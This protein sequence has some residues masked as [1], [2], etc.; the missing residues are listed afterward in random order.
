MNKNMAA[1]LKRMSE[2]ITLKVYAGM[3]IALSEYCENLTPD[4][5][6]QI[7]E[8]SEA[9]WNE[10]NQKDIDIYKWCKDVSGVDLRKFLTETH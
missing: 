10:V 7:C 8:L 1:I 9:I 2:N 4:D 5:I 3:C 6:L